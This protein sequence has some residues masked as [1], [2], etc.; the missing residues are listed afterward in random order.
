MWPNSV[1]DEPNSVSFVVFGLRRQKLSCFLE[2]LAD[3]ILVDRDAESVKVLR[4]RGDRTC[5]GGGGIV[6][7]R[8]HRHAYQELEKGFALAGPNPFTFD[9]L[10]S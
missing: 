8:R 5:S 10:S 7:V 6:L 1:S 9:S 3:R 2:P 4:D